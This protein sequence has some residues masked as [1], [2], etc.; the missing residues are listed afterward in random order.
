MCFVF[1]YSIHYQTT[2]V[3]P[4]AIIEIEEMKNMNCDQ[5]IAKNSLNDYWTPQNSKIR[6]EFNDICKDQQKEASSSGLNPYVEFCNPGGFAPDKKIENA[7][8]S[9]DHHTCLWDSK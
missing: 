8:H 7:T 1:P 2:V 9:F 5:I 3:I 4:N 6:R